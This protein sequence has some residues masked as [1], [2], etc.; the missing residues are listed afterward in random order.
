[1]NSAQMARQSPGIFNRQ[2]NPAFISELLAVSDLPPKAIALL[3]NGRLALK[4]ARRLTG[5]DSGAIEVLIDLFSRIKA[6]SGK[7]L[8]M[9]TCFTEVCKKERIAPATLFNETGLQALFK[10]DIQDLGQKETRYG[11]IWFIAGFRTLNRPGR[12]PDPMS[13]GFSLKTGSGFICRIILNP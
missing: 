7:Q 2:L 9:I 3:E 4:P 10:R 11:S 5:Y 13:G 1:M 6:S 12:K 8:D